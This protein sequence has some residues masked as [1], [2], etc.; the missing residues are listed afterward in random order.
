MLRVRNNQSRRPRWCKPE[1]HTFSA[2]TPC[3]SRQDLPGDRL[4]LID[5]SPKQTAAS[6]AVHDSWSELLKSISALVTRRVAGFA[7]PALLSLTLLGQSGCTSLSD[8]APIPLAKVDMEQMYGGWYLIATRRNW[9]E[10]GLV[11]PYDVY[12]KRP[13]GDIREDFYV[14]KGSFAAELKHFEVHDW[15]R[16]GTDNAHWRVQIMWPIDLPFLVLH[17]SPGYRFVLFGE[18]NRQL[19]WIYSRTPTLTDGEYEELLG[20][21]AALGYDTSEFVKFIQTPEQIGKPGYWSEGI[22]Q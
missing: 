22:E 8:G 4:I 3:H 13:D 18:Q 2:H 6:R 16:P 12:S 7:L 20:H 1:Q 21:F 11:A 17:T 15:V 19:G 14:H 10:K 9:F 5:P